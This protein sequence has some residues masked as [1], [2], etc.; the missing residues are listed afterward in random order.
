MSKYQLVCK[1]CGRVIGDFGHWFSQDQKCTC[2]STHA[3]VEYPDVDFATLDKAT[4][5]ASQDFYRYFDF[6]PVARRENIVSLGEGAIDMERWAHLEQFARRQ[7][8]DC[9]VYIY[10]NDKNGGTG[11]FKDI[12]ASL[13]ATAMKEHH[14][15]SYCLASTGNAG[16][17]YATY[18]AQAG[19]ECSVFVPADVEADTLQALEATGQR[20]VVSSGDYGAAKAEAAAFHEQAHVM[21]SAGN[22]DPLRVESKRTMVFECLRQL[23]GLP[24]VYVQAV[25]G[26]TGPIAFDKGFRD[27][28][29]THPSL[30]MPRML[31][32][33]QDT[34]DPM[35]QSWERA[36][37]AGFP[38]G[39]ERDF[40]K[41]PSTRTRVSILTATT[42][43][44][45]PLV[46]PIV[47]RSGG[48]FV[49]V[50]EAD[51]AAYGHEMRQQTGVLLG[52]AS[53]VCY[54]G[55]YAALER[56]LIHSGDRV[57]LN[58]GEGAARAAWFRNEV[59]NIR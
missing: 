30:R 55:F 20:V 41:L 46:A 34:C 27:L 40:V 35:V 42:P 48:S 17:A 26:G 7:G 47:R 1:Q 43:G 5:D 53:A 22:I 56:G 15:P 25:A 12:S 4:R 23:G 49:R 14:V 36:E 58:T 8:V 52:P 16:T 13:A 57:L 38:E 19:V 2:G 3:E 54:A 10:R 32:V 24:D 37:A 29:P 44:M 9:E 45:Y 11:T 31:L 50:R 39:W 18:L 6:L 33:Q 28:Q 59:D 21:I 51:L